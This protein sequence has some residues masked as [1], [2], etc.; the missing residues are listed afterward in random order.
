AQA[1]SSSGVAHVGREDD[2][3]MRPV[4]GDRDRVVGLANILH[5]KTTRWLL[6]PGTSMKQAGPS[7][8]SE[9]A[10][11][12][13]PNVASISANHFLTETCGSSGDKPYRPVPPGD[14]ISRPLQWLR[15]RWLARDRSRQ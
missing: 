10:S 9:S 2:R 4:L 7:S 3:V 11:V 6:V 14:A 13:S 1:T 8:D 5:K 12:S 15:H